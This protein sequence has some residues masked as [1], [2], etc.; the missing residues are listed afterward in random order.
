VLAGPV[1]VCVAVPR[2]AV[3]RPFTYVLNDEHAASTGSLV[4]VPFH[5]RTVKGWVLGPA[6]EVPEGR[7]LPVRKVHSH[8]RFFDES[9][10][11][12]LQWMSERYIAPLAT[13]IERSH[14]PRVVSEEL[15]GDSAAVD[16][17]TPARSPSARSRGAPDGYAPPVPA[18]EL[19]TPSRILDRYGGERLL[20]PGATTWLRPL[21]HD[22]QTVCV[23]AVEACLSVGKS[24][25]VLVPEAEPLPATARAVL[26]AFGDRAIAF[27]GGEP[28]ERYR[29]WLRILDGRFDVVVGTR[30][31]VFSPLASLGLIWISREVHPGH[32]EDRS[33]YY[34][35]RDVAMARARLDRAACVLAS[36]S[37]SV[38]TLVQAEADSVRVAR[39]PRR[40]ERAVA[41]LVETATPEAEDRSPRLTALLKR[42]RS[43]ALI[44][45]RR[46]YGVARV[47]RSCGDPAA[48][49]VCRGPIVVQ[50]GRP[51]CRVCGA[52]GVCASCGNNSFGV[53]R[54]GTERTA[55]WASRMTSAP[56][57]QE[58]GAAQPPPLPGPGRIVVGTAATVKDAGPLKL[59]LVAILD[60]DR[61]LARAG[62]HA[63]EQT[64]ATW[65]ESAAWAAP[66]DEGGRVLLHTRRP[67]NPAIQA[68]I[69]WEPVPFLLAHARTREEAGF[70]PG[71]AVFR[72]VGS[73]ALGELLEAAGAAMV[74][75]TSVNGRTLC[76]VAVPPKDL[77]RFRGEV[78]RLAGLGRVTRVE[79][80]PQL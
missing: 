6:V 14:P 1:D 59:D 38:E 51:L 70:M 61:A 47:C 17:A 31:A 35:A 4:S 64:L 27:L 10:L 71:H 62:V 78:L 63:A 43:A 68:L 25:V 45:S 73:D 41:P 37:P 55:E 40:M 12:L 24:A 76:L 16:A 21:P 36:L 30:P 7:L 46:G 13:V 2:L 53:E 74:L 67:A 8:V 3:D 72:V 29:T 20:E 79:A 34:H 54:G 26:D 60:A 65:M 49:A 22:E 48:C 33:P 9:M 75:S 57:V 15:S 18:T 80:E 11:R 28:R 50:R 56:V 66:R 39:P 19:T 52:D 44:V 32:R 77:A 58:P 69:R 42:A 5:G 23:D